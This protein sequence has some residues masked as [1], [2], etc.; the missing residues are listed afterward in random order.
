MLLRPSGRLFS[1]RWGSSELTFMRAFTDII[2]GIKGV[3]AHKLDNKLSLNEN[4]NTSVPDSRR[5]YRR[6]E[7][8]LAYLS[9]GLTHMKLRPRKGATLGLVGALVLTLVLLGSCFFFLFRIIG[10]D[11]QSINATDA[12]ALSAAR[13]IL[14][15]GVPQNTVAPE[16]QGLGVNVH[17][18]EP[19]PVSGLMNIFAYNRA[20]G[21]CALIGINSVQDGTQAGIDNANRVTTRL[22]EFGDALNGAILASGQLG[23]DS[24]VAFENVANQNNVKMNGQQS[25]ANLSGNLDFTSVPTGAGGVGGKSNVYFNSGAVTGNATLALLA[26]RAEDTSGSI[27]SSAQP[28]DYNA[29]SYAQPPLFQNNR[30]LLKAYEPINLDPRLSPIYLCAVNPTA[31]PHLIDAGRY[32]AGAPRLG[33]APV[34]AVRGRTQTLETNR[35][36]ANTFVNAMA[37]AVVGGLYNEYPVTI[38]HGYVRIRNGPDARVANPTLPAVFGAVDGRANIFNNQLWN[39]AGGGGGIYV[40]DNGVFGTANSGAG[41]MID[42]FAVYNTS[43][44]NPSNPDDNGLEASLDPSNGAYQSASTQAN[45]ASVYSQ[46]SFNPAN[47]GTPYVDGDPSFRITANLNRIARLPNMLQIRSRRLYC[48]TFDFDDPVNPN[49]TAWLPTFGGNYGSG[50]SSSNPNPGETYTGLEYLKAR[51][52]T[53]WVAATQSGDF[54]HYSFTIGGVPN[55]SGSKV[56]SRAGVGYATPT[57]T[58]HSTAAFGTISTPGALLRQLVQNGATCSNPD[59]ANQWNDPSTILGQLLQRC[60]EILPSAD[61]VMVRNLLF[62]PG[63]LAGA[64]GTQIDL[65]QYLYI[66]LVPGAS[67]LTISPNPPAFLNGLPEHNQPGATLPDGNIFRPAC[68][69]DAEFGGAVG[70]HVDAA[71]GVF[72]NALGDSGLHYQPFTVTGHVETYDYVTWQPSSG[73]KLL[74]GEMTFYQHADAGGSF[75]APN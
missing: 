38:T 29:P 57:N 33:Y 72:G 40:S 68:G 4:N 17:T 42:A 61:W 62:S 56:Y 71:A 34:N 41:T 39:G 3:A 23:N 63:E 5:N 44:N 45:Y 25:S 12:G 21:T 43:G 73:S 51:V 64:T 58:I 54:A 1:R 36:N 9:G 55:D 20:A 53:E 50:A 70:N 48:N 15:V 67:T 46:S 22:Q 28:F 8:I 32:N 74:L 49:C 66:Y 6:D 10:G 26:Q 24:A 35:T 19:D 69:Q 13:S 37:C 18:G 31:R 16:F 27:R 14:A 30:P 47:G 59:D 75:S 7:L 2:L 11:S 52:I 60:R 65:G